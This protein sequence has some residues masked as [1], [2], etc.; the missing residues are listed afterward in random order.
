MLYLKAVNVFLFPIAK[1]SS[2]QSLDPFR[3]KDDLNLIQNDRDTYIYRIY[4][5]DKGYKDTRI[6]QFY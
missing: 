4:N 2:L 5:I 6:Q 3:H 1:G